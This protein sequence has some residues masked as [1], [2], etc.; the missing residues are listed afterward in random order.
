M[1]HQETL[2]EE[3]KRAQVNIY[4]AADLHISNPG[5]FYSFHSR[6]QPR[7]ANL[8]GVPAPLL[9]RSR[10]SPWGD[11]KCRKGHR[12]QDVPWKKNSYLLFKKYFS[13]KRAHT[14]EQSMSNHTAACWSIIPSTSVLHYGD[15][16]FYLSIHL[17][18]YLSTYLPTNLPTYPSQ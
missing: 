7:R 14:G 4:G 3:S 9:A 1:G 16:A 11:R 18:I 2:R 15:I 8:W 6:C 5:W 13:I 10:H 17:Y 12:G